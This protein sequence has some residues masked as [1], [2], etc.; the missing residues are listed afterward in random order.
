[1][2]VSSKS[3]ASA[4]LPCPHPCFLL[5]RVLKSTLRQVT[6]PTCH[7]MGLQ[8]VVSTE[9][10]IWAFGGQSPLREDICV[11]HLAQEPTPFRPKRSLASLQGGV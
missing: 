8:S 6:Q 5:Q 11:D 10:F 9:D 1:M 3:V 7:S 4:L 2:F